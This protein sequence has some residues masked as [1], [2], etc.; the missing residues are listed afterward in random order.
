M[1]TFPDP[2][3]LAEGTYLVR[4]LAHLP[5]T[6]FA[7]HVNSLVIQGAEPVIVDTGAAR[8]RD[9]WIEQVF[10]LVDPQDV[11]WIFLSND[12][13][14]HTGNLAVALDTCPRAT[15]VTSPPTRPWVASELGVP[16]DRRRHV[17]D[18]E[19]LDLPDRRLIA[20]RPPTFDSP[21]TR[22]LY[23]SATGLYWSSDA[24]G[25]AVP[26]AV[27]SVA[28]LC[29]TCWHE[30]SMAYSSLLS[31]WH[32]VVD[33]DKFGSWIDRIADLGASVIA[34]AHGPAL[35]GPSIDLA[36]EA[37]RRLPDLP[38]VAPGQNVLDELTRCLVS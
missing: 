21:T 16:P 4:P 13:R 22:G 28:D 17:G 18:G 37:M 2:I 3:R 25:T 34:G 33:P 1:Y 31:P 26:E 7:L 32:T 11:R 29:P 20:V 27:D 9:D 19:T 12:D 38:A 15:V 30:A 10:S 6:P 36:L 23:D 35:L 8:F 5:G 24:F 14:D